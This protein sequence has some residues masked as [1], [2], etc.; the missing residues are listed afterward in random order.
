[1]CLAA[2]QRLF[3]CAEDVQLLLHRDASS[4]CGEDVDD[5]CGLIG[6]PVAADL[7]FGGELVENLYH[8]RCLV[9]G[10]LARVQLVEVDVVGS[11]PAQASFARL[12]N[13]SP[14]DVDAGAAA[15]VLIED[16]PNLCRN[17]HVLAERFERLPE[18]A[19][20]M[21]ATVRVRRVEQSHATFIRDANSGDRHLV[22]DLTPTG[23]GARELPWAAQRPRTG[24]ESGDLPLADS[25]EG[26][27][28]AGL[29]RAGLYRAAHR[30]FLEIDL[31]QFDR[32]GRGPL[33]LNREYALSPID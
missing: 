30:H 26:R 9:R 10:D 27:H 28:R 4:A 15:R 29:Y 23:R 31:P 22:V 11:Q 7:P 5:V 21:A 14:A 12:L 19:F 8:G 3:V 17:N 20:G 32:S 6:R 1:M 13:V 24:T 16:E 33:R 25:P 2:R 18:D